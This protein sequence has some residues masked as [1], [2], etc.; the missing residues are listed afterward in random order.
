[1]HRQDQN[2]NAI[3]MHKVFIYFIVFAQGRLCW[4][5]YIPAEKIIY[6]LHFYSCLSSVPGGTG[7]EG[8]H[9]F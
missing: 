4:T 1:M 7:A 6:E 2:V 3:I 8:F 5:N 9:R